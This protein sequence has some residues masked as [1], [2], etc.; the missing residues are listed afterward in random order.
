LN[1]GPNI[2]DNKK[3]HRRD[4]QD[5]KNKDNDSKTD[6]TFSFSC[7]VWHASISKLSLIC[8]FVISDSE[9][10]ISGSDSVIS[11]SDSVISKRD[12]KTRRIKTMNQR[13]DTQ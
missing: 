4:T 9:S 3:D 7:N 5:K 6:R 1:D 11:D 12:Y 8:D 10:V 2:K 13:P